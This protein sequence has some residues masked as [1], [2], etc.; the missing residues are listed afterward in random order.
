[1]GPNREDVSAEATRTV[2]GAEVFVQS[3]R[4]GTAHAVLAARA[5]LEAGCEDLLIVFADTPLVRPQTYAACSM[6]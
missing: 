6:R 1:M 5:A 2:P 4:L 3:E